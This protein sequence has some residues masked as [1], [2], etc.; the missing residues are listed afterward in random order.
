MECLIGSGG[1]GGVGGKHNQCK[2]PLA[3]RALRVRCGFFFFVYSLS[4]LETSVQKFNQGVLRKVQHRITKWPASLFL[5]GT[6]KN[7]KQVLRQATCRPLC[8]S[9]L[10]TVTESRNNLNVSIHRMDEEDMRC[11]WT[12]KMWLVPTREYESAFKR[13]KAPIYAMRWTLKAWSWVKE[14]RHQRNK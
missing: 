2:T 14:T 6:Q 7:W 10:V 9:A 4:F 1:R 11:P 5:D 12:N 13:N 8:I 3:S